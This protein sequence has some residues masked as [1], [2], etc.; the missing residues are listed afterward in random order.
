MPKLARGI[1]IALSFCI[2]SFCLGCGTKHAVCSTPSSSSSSSSTCSC[3][4][5]ACPASFY[6]YVYAVGDSGEIATFP[7]HQI[8]AELGTPTTTTGP[9]SSVG[10]AQVESAFLYASDPQAQ[11]GP[12]IDE[13]TINVGTGA[14]TTVAGSPFAM[15]ASAVP[16][17]L[18]VAENL[19][20]AGPFLY[21]ADAGKIDALQVNSGT[22]ALTTVPGSPFTSGTNLYLTVDPTSHFVFAAGEDAPGGVLAFTINQSTGGL[23][24]VPGSPFLIGSSANPVTVGE[25]VVD[26]LGIFVYVTL[27]AAGQVAALSID[28]ASGVLTPVPGSPF[29]AGTGAFAIA[30]TFNGILYVANPTANSISGYSINEMTG[31]LTQVASSPF[32]ADGVTA[33]TVDGYGDLYAYG[34]SG[35]AILN[36]GGTGVLTP[37][38]SP[39]ASPATAAMTYVGP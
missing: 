26:P 22:G 4:G 17:G 38:G 18:A 7:V 23:T 15:G 32:A 31:A 20:S 11:S 13:W 21:V 35:M 27:P 28:P 16:N 14:L 37:I 2:L 5:G 10:V 29:A 36:T 19:G 33:L 1:F 30:V 24:P 3:G 25:I 39:V 9:A 8:G 34:S 6:A 12:S